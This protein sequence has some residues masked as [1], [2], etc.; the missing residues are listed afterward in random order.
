LLLKL[1]IE[2]AFDEQYEEVFGYPALSRG[3]FGSVE[4]RF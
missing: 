4:W 3:I 1:R 2:N